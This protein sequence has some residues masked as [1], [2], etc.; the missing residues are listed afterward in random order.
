MTQGVAERMRPKD[1]RSML[2]IPL[3]ELAKR[4]KVSHVTVI[5]SERGE[6]PIRLITAYALLKALNSYRAEQDM[7][8]L[9]IR[10][11]EWNIIGED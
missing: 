6:K 10:D 11:I 2:R 4:A 9:G 3:K 8:P 5:E 7:E 1:A